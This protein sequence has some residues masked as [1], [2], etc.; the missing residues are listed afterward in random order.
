[1]VLTVVLAVVASVQV[2]DAHLL[3]VYRTATAGLLVV[4]AY[5]LRGVSDNVN[6][7]GKILHNLD[8]RVKLLEARNE[9]EDAIRAFW[10]TRAAEGEGRRRTD[11]KP[12]GHSS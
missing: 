8:G 3:W 1:M 4:V 9:W 7:Q 11:P 10:E 12:Q 2:P 6:E 5:F